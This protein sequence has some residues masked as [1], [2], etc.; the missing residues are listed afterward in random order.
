MTDVLEGCGVWG[1]GCGVCALVYH[2]VRRIGRHEHTKVEEKARIIV[3]DND[4]YHDEF[5]QTN[6][7]GVEV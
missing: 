6:Y 1:V 7:T 3:R 5:D 4:D 2:R